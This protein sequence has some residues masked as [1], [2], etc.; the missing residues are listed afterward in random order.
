M[1]TGSGKTR[2]AELAI[3]RFLL[4]TGLADDSICLYIAPFRSLAWEIEGDLRRLFEDRLFTKVSGMYSGLE[5]SPV[6]MHLTSEA[7]IV[8]T[9]P[10]KADALVR[11]QPDLLQRVQLVIADEGHLIGDDAPGSSGRRGIAYEM[12]LERLRRIADGQTRVVVLSA[13]LSEP[14]AL[15]RWLGSPETAATDTAWRPTRLAIGKMQHLSTGQ[16]RI[17]YTHAQAPSGPGDLGHECFLPN[18]GWAKK[19][20]HKAALALSVLRLALGG[21]TLVFAS[22]PNWADSVA[23]QL[24]AALEGDDIP[25]DAREDL[26][27]SDDEDYRVIRD[28]CILLARDLLGEKHLV[29]KALKHGIVLH[30]GNVPFLLRTHLERLARHAQTKLVVATSTLASGVNLPVRTVVVH[31][32]D[33]GRGER[34]SHETFWNICGR[35]GRAGRENEGQ[36]LF[37]IHGGARE[38]RRKNAK[39]RSYLNVR[40]G[41]GSLSSLGTYLAWLAERWRATHPSVDLAELCDRLASDDDSW[42][43]EADATHRTRSARE[44]DR[45]LIALEQELG[46]NLASPDALQVILRQGLLALQEDGGSALDSGSASEILNA[47]MTSLAQRVPS[48]ETRRRFYRAGLYIPDALALEESARAWV[49]FVLQWS[50]YAAWTPDERAE[51][52]TQGVKLALERLPHTA[53]PPVA[54]GLNRD[55]LAEVVS[56]WLRGEVPRHV[57]DQISR[58][59]ALVA[60]VHSQLCDY[61]LPWAFNAVVAYAGERLEEQGQAV[62]EAAR[63]LATFLR[64]GTTSIPAA[65]LLSAGLHPRSLAESLAAGYDLPDVSPQRVLGWMASITD[66]ELDALGAPPL[67]RS[68]LR[69]IRERALRS[70]LDTLEEERKSLPRLP[71]DEPARLDWVSEETVV[72]VRVTPEDNAY[73]LQVRT[74]DGRLLGRRRVRG[75]VAP[76]WWMVPEQV[77]ARV[78]RIVGGQDRM[79]LQLSLKRV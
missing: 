25:S 41:E 18:I 46:I 38:L 32:L 22:K 39:I 12:L 5:V 50:D 59:P 53:L 16:V 56:L 69:G 11:H 8:V 2:V 20:D 58:D 31:S 52:L 43:D 48:A 28:S 4:D 76:A 57:A 54:P 55:D 78:E 13:I 34:V 68:V 10:E 26:R 42:L 79:E 64:T 67:S 14:R 37:W 66:T 63:Y 19:S 1:P 35:A 27:P 77:V 71:I 47:H 36:I 44:L 73:R 45:H 75:S 72:D 70:I 62:P 74:L 3:L 23:K 7:R 65:F 49:E 24:V 61:H 29:T 30:H 21:A 60:K 33:I 51:C 17:E 40:R 9:T 15:A 6:D